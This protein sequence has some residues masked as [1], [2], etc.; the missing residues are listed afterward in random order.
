M[1]QII[2]IVVCLIIYILW[3]NHTRL[4]WYVECRNIRRKY[5]FDYISDEAEFFIML[6]WLGLIVL[7]IWIIYKTWG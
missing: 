7:V 6:H 3:A 1:G 5:K 2:L 4:E